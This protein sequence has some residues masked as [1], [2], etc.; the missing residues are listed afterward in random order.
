[1]IIWDTFVCPRKW[2]RLACFSSREIIND[3]EELV[4]ELAAMYKTLKLQ[5]YQTMNS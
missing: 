2:Y 3:L 1:M 5:L 4:K